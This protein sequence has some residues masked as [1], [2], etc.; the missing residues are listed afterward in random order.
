MNI[1]RRIW[2]SIALIK[3]VNHENTYLIIMYLTMLNETPAPS[4]FRSLPPS[5]S[6]PFCSVLNYSK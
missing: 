5:P 4:S 1:Q 3:N 6:L 2:T